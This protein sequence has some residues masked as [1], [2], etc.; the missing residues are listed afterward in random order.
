MKSGYPSAGI[1]KHG[2]KCFGTFIC[3][4]GLRWVTNWL[5]IIISEE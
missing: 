5:D 2:K 3:G 4:G 1:E